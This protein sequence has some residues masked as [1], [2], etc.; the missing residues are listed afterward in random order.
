MNQTQKSVLVVGSWHLGSVVGVGI[1]SLGH[2]VNLWDQNE[3]TAS[4]WKSGAPPIH[5]PGLAELARPHFNENLFWAT[6]LAKTVSKADWI[7]L[8]Y[9]TPI[10]EKDEV[11]LDSV[12]EGLKKVLENPI[13]PNTNFFFT[14]QLPVGTSRSYLKQIQEQF[15]A[16][17]GHV[18]YQPEK[19]RKS[20][21]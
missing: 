10:N 21:V 17:S 16:W 20:V 19:D 4:S 6:D 2:T 11:I 18:L 12:Q 9:D 5:E 1:A 15:P 13:S 8:A 14:S 7:V 3:R